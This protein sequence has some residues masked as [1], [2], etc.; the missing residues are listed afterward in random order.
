MN[1][2]RERKR[3]S[4]QQAIDRRDLKAEKPSS[5]NILFMQTFSPAAPSIIPPNDVPITTVKV[6]L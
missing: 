5:V 6:I 2:E 4:S 3:G 1:E